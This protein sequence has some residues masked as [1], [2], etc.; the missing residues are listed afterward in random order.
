MK[1][2][3]TMAL[4]FAL[5]LSLAVPAYAY[6]GSTSNNTKSRTS[7]WDWWNDY[8]PTEPE[9]AEIGV[10]TITESRFYHSASV[11]SLRNP[12]QVSWN[13]VE[14]TDSYEIE[15]TKAD[16]T[17]DI[18]TAST[19]SLMV[20]NM[21]CAAFSTTLLKVDCGTGNFSTAIFSFSSIISHIS[22]PHPANSKIGGSVLL[23]GPW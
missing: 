6:D 3:L 18:F 17:V 19:N 20:K 7:W 4:A 10:T 12:L 22:L 9:A 11:A 16:G 23:I 14:G 2:I 21:A 13:A 5:V 1:K 8:T 15:L